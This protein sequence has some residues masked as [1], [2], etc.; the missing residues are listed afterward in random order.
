MSELQKH[1]TQKIGIMGGT[2]DPIHFGHLLIAQS[3]AEEFGLSRVIFLPT[4]KS[5]H[6][7][8]GQVSSPKLRCRMVE[9]AIADRSI[10][11]LSEMEAVNT[12]I[13]YT[14]RTLQTLTERYPG[15]HF[16]F[17]M[18]ED[19]L[20]NF[21]KWRNP[22]MICDL[23][24]I[25][26]AVR[27]DREALGIGIEEKLAAVREQYHADIYVLHAPNFSISSREIRQRVRQGKSIHYMLPEKVEAF[28]R[29]H[30][31]YS[32]RMDGYDGRDS[33]D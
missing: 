26:V 33:N 16:Y 6:K 15:V 12:E 32:Q 10:F 20:D 23:A 19:S 25:L 28:I 17:I 5:P 30:T 22:Q 4:G 14:F 27:T 29:E 24:T 3:A 13:N 11:E 21:S 9:E 8:P 31:L 1:Q 7:S 2:F 18:G